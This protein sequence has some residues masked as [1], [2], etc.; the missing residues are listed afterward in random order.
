ME[1]AQIAL[2]I[3]N[4]CDTEGN[5][6]CHNPGCLGSYTAYRVNVWGLRNPGANRQANKDMSVQQA[7]NYRA[8]MLSCH[9]I[10]KDRIM[11]AHLPKATPPFPGMLHSGDH[12]SVD[13]IVSLQ[14]ILLPDFCVLVLPPAEVQQVEAL[15]EKVAQLERANRELKEEMKNKVKEKEK[16]EALVE[17]IK[18]QVDWLNEDAKEDV[19]LCEPRHRELV[20]VTFLNDV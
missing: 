14:I 15:K 9:S 7:D 1:R 8:H 19:P 12:K 3:R 6:F 4:N 18:D 11:L 20:S 13:I 10:S 2:H 17:R 5:S 16:M